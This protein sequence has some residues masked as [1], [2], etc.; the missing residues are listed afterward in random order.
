[1]DHDP[2]KEFE[3]LFEKLEPW[4]QQWVACRALLRLLPIVGVRADF[5]FWS[6]PHASIQALE[7]AP[8]L[9]SMRDIVD[10]GEQAH[11]ASFAALVAGNDAYLAFVHTDKYVAREAVASAFALFAAYASTEF[12]RRIAKVPINPR[13]DFRRALAIDR[14]FAKRAWDAAFETSVQ[15]ARVVARLNREPPSP[16]GWKSFFE[17]PLWNPYWPRPGFVALIVDQFEVALRNVNCE[18]TGQRYSMNCYS[19]AEFEKTQQ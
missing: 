7:T 15:D 4:Q 8:W 6:D 2:Q 5:T 9:M 10:C 13:E 16:F 17:R 14:E 19:A 12:A 1:M 11:S 3:V 18:T